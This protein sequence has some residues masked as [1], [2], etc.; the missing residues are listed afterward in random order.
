MLNLV[1]STT[2]AQFGQSSQ[3]H[4]ASQLSSDASSTIAGLLRQISEVKPSK[5]SSQYV[6]G[7]LV[8]MQCAA[9]QRLI[10]VL[11]QMLLRTPRIHRNFITLHR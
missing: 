4:H 10:L 9:A 2:A 8:I 5:S 11:L 7:H 1:D 3:I 6:H